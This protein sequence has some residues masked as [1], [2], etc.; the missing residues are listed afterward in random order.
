[1][2]HENQVKSINAK[3]AK[4]A[5]EGPAIIKDKKDEFRSFMDE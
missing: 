5:K 2:S 3:D 4:D 1:M